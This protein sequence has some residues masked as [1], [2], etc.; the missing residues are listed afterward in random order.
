LSVFIFAN[1]CY[2][3]VVANT[4]T[5][6]TINIV[7]IFHMFNVRTSKS[8]FMSNP[9]KNKWLV[10]A[11]VVGIG[12]TLL[13]A[14]VPFLASAFKLTALTLEQWL[15]VLVASLSIIPIVEIG[16]FIDNHITK[17]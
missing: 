17:E 15:I 13:V 7:Q 4:M 2:N 9:F 10:L 3:Q 11:L 1:I 16:K 14:L 6:L 12:L 5:F 8:I